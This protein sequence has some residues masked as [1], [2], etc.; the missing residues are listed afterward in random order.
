MRHAVGSAQLVLQGMAGPVLNASAAHKAVVGQRGGPFYIGAGIVVGR[1]GKGFRS[2]IH[3][4]HQQSFGKAVG[5]FHTAGGGEIALHDVAHHVDNAAGCLPCREGE[6]EFR[7]ENGK[8][9][10]QNAV[11]A[12]A[13]LAQVVAAGDHSVAAALT[14]GAGHRENHTHRKSLLDNGFPAEKIPEIA[15]VGD[16]CGDGLGCVDDR[17]A[18]HGY[19][20]VDIAVASEFDTFIDKC[21]DRVGL[22]ATQLH[23]LYADRLQRHAQPGPAAR[24]SLHTSG[25]TQ[26]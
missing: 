6:R 18:S 11:G 3:K 1:I 16:A 19:Q 4:C 13:Q 9:G 2:H 14:A 15:L 12:Q 24:W 20:T 23:H 10:T 25:R 8:T 5:H 21:V 7:V 26:A 22:N 17:A